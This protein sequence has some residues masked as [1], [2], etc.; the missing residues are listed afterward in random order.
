MMAR[1]KIMQ[2]AD[3]VMGNRSDEKVCKPLIQIEMGCSEREDRYRHL[4]LSEM[5]K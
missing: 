1:K 2:E 5:A 4:R 3:Q